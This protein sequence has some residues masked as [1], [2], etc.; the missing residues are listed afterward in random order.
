MY[1]PP[2]TLRAAL[3]LRRYAWCAPRSM[4]CSTVWS[5]AECDTIIALFT[6]AEL[7]LPQLEVRESCPEPDRTNGPAD[8]RNTI[9][10]T[11]LTELL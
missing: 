9:P 10:D 8:A 6:D 3:S 2:V 7:R 11:E 5:N 4:N 1:I